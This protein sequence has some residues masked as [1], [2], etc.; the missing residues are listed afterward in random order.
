[1]GRIIFFK[2]LRRWTVILNTIERTT[3]DDQSSLERFR[4]P[5]L[6]DGKKVWE[7]VKST[8]VLD[9][10]SSYQYLMWCSYFSKTSIVVEQDDQI[11]GFISGFI[12]PEA[13]DTLFVWQVAVAESERGRGLATKMLQSLLEQDA[14]QDVQFVEATISPSNI[15]SQ[16]LFRGLSR[17]WNADLNIMPC[18]KAEDFPE[19]GHEDELIHL[20]GPFKK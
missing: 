7:L 2:T 16:R 5:T 17:K 9:L 3:S 12:K 6:D 13:P 15:P 11:V 20:V 14:L 19:Q 8:G 18:F 4:E 1:M 10:N